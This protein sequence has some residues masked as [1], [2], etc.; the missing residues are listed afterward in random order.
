[1]DAARA[2]LASHHPTDTEERTFQLLGLLWTGADSAVLQKCARELFES[3]Q[4]DGGWGDAYSTGEAL[5]ALAGSGS[6]PVS[7]RKWRRGIEFLVK[8]QA[9]DGTWHVKSRLHPPAPL[10]PNY[11]ESD[12]PYGH[13]QFL[14]AMG[15][16]W[17]VMALA[18]ALGPAHPA[19]IPSLVKPSVPSWAEAAIFGSDA[20]GLDPNAATPFGTTVLMMAAPNAAKMKVLL[21]HG[22]N[23]NAVTKDGYSALLMSAHYSGSGP[24]L[25]LLLDRGAELHQPGS[26][27]HAYPLA[28]AAIAG[29]AEAVTQLH[30]A[31]D[32]VDDIYDYAGLQPAAPLVLI[33][34]MDET[35]VAQAL[36]DAGATVDK[37]DGDGL[38]ALQWA[39]LANKTNMARLLIEH[40]AD[41][42]HVDKQGMTAL[43]YAV[44][45]DFGDAEMIDLLKK[46]GAKQDARTREGLTALDLERK[47]HH[48]P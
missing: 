19:E 45:I 27:F 4:P 6:V 32:A 17:A 14:S 3:Q 38:T 25:Q 29:N 28:L 13:D 46:S 1:M 43:L 37:P 20:G 2:W 30:A 9:Q 39:T 40:G 26:L 12:Y 34:S 44:S 7:D 33:S 11:F 10:S 24:A 8:T 22:A 36:L 16:S 48:S 47:Y 21:D 41:V 35:A 42:N 18:R 23:P 5:V 15:A 31:G